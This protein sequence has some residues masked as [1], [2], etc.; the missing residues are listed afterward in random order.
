MIGENG[1]IHIG[2]GGDTKV[3]SAVFKGTE[4]TVQGGFRSTVEYVLADISFAIVLIIFVLQYWGV[5]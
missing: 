1:Q 2:I 3:P 5:L 4:W